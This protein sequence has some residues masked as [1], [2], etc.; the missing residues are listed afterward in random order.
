MVPKK[1]PSCNIVV[2]AIAAIYL[3][4]ARLQSAEGRLEVFGGVSGDRRIKWL[5]QFLQSLAPNLFK[6]ISKSQRF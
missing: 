2:R 4:R 6:G 5:A 3:V 1:T